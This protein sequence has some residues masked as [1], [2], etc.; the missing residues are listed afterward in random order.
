MPHVC[1]NCAHT[2]SKKLETCPKC[3]F[4]YFADPAR[5]R[6]EL[7]F[8]KSVICPGC[9][10]LFSLSHCTDALSTT[11]QMWQGAI[12]RTNAKN[13]IAS[14]ISSAKHLFSFFAGEARKDA[15][16][17]ICS[18]CKR[19]CVGCPYCKTVNPMSGKIAYEFEPVTCKSC[20]KEFDVFI[21]NG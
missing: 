17:S 12:A 2:Y 5:S 13:A 18:N 8:L 11:E 1:F 21:F 7:K 15:E 9:K 6:K 16:Q 3:D 10:K 14:G 19:Y 20:K 4:Q